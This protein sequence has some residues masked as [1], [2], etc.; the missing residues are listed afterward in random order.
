MSHPDEKPR[1]FIQG[2]ITQQMARPALRAEVMRALH[3]RPQ[4]E[5]PT[6]MDV[7]DIETLLRP[8]D[9]GVWS[10]LVALAEYDL[11][12]L[13]PRD[14]VFGRPARVVL[15]QPGR[16]WTPAPEGEVEPWE[17]Q[18]LRYAYQVNGELCS[19]T[20]EDWAGVWEHREYGGD[21]DLGHELI[22]WRHR[23]DGYR[24]HVDRLTPLDRQVDWIEF[25]IWAAGETVTKRID[26][27]A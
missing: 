4:R 19:G 27:R 14:K 24:V 9:F 17:D 20:L 13:F 15:T 11:V 5:H 26:G 1:R 10:T 18:P 21:V 3:S 22:T 7:S 8:R 6:F 25:R 12:E 16:K 23:T 2:P